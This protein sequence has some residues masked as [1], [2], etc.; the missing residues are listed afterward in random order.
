MSTSIPI[1][2]DPRENL[3]RQQW[4]TFAAKHEMF[5]RD[6]HQTWF[7]VLNQVDEFMQQNSR[8][9][10]IDSTDAHERTLAGFLHTQIQLYGLPDSS[11]SIV[12]DKEIED[13]PLDEKALAASASALLDAR[14][15]E[16]AAWTSGK[17]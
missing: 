7:S 9:P 15:K 16:L 4:E 6:S 3:R 13:E 5:L 8:A 2:A 12:A 1:V 14:N 17:I 10:Q 11:A